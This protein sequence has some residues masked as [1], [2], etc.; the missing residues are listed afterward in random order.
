MLKAEISGGEAAVI[1][2]R[3]GDNAFHLDVEGEKCQTAKRLWLGNALL[4][5]EISGGEGAVI[6]QRVPPA[7]LELLSGAADKALPMVRS[8]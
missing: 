8:L 2:Q 1:S 5:A 7:F 6:S 4:K 3:V